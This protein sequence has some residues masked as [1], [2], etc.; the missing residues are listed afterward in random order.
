MIKR[1]AYLTIDDSPSERMDDM[2]AALHGD[3]IPAIF[4][5]RGDSLEKHPESAVSA[6]RK[7][8]IIANHAY[9]HRRSSQIS[10]E[11]MA[12]EII[13][14]QNLIDAAYR[15][16]GVSGHPKLFRFPHMDRG[17]GGWIID[18]NAVAEPSRTDIIRMFSDGLNIS[19]DPPD[20]AALEKKRR[21]QDFL[22]GQ[23]FIAPLFNRV[24]FPWYRDT[25]MARAIDAM[26]TFSTSDWMLNA[27]HKGKWPWKS[28]EDLKSR[29]DADPW[30]QRA[31]SAHIILAHDSAE[32]FDESL[33]LIRYARASGIEFIPHGA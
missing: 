20:A 10:L 11:D 26:F 5:C 32:I 31:D 8:F 25:E 13:R 14:T 3:G 27:R 28:L 19:L 17:T 21:L 1:E 2:V 9:H 22:K 23:G 18:Y 30:L 7:G 15:G 6:I 29:M 4:F 24:T 33:A 12:D 16:A